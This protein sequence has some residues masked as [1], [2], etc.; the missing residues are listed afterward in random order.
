MDIS[1][2]LTPTDVFVTLTPANTLAKLAFS[3]IYDVLTAG[4]QYG[5]D[6]DAPAVHRMDVGLLQEYDADV[7]LLQR[8]IERRLEEGDG[9]TSQ[10]LTEPNSESEAAEIRLLGMIWTGRFL[11]GFQSPPSAPQIGWTVGKGPLPSPRCA[12]LFLCTIAF[13]RKHGINLRSFHARF[14]FN[15]QNWALFIAR[16]SR[17]PHAE[18]TVNGGAVSSQLYALNQSSMKIRFDKLEYDFKYASFSATD[19]FKTARDSYLTSVLKAPQLVDFEMPTPL[20]SIRT[21]G[22]W[23]LAKPL[24][25][26]GMGR[27]FLASNSKNDIVAVKTVERNPS[28][29]RSVDHEIQTY[30]DLT[31]LAEKWDEGQRIVRVREVIHNRLSSKAPF[32]EVAIVMEPMTPQTFLKLIGRRSMGGAR[33]MS[34]EAARA[35]RDTLLGVRVLH[36]QRWM[37]GDLKPANI[38]MIGTPPR[39]VLLDV[40]QATYLAPSATLD[41]KPG[42]GGTLNYLAPERELE[43][44]DHLV[45]IWSL[46]VIGYELTYGHHPWRFSLNPWR[47]DKKE[48]EELRSAFHEKYQEAIDRLTCDSR[49]TRNSQEHI[50]LGDLL[51]QMLRH[52][53]TRTNHESRIDIDKAL[54]HEAWG[55]LLSDEPRVKRGRPDNYGE[56]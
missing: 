37:H 43:P 32:E 12:D 24:G 29:E 33:G 17:S 23:T 44:H 8:E 28:T 13:A 15:L 48:C 39:A 34:M 20:L 3:D 42:S 19:D 4:R 14:N 35:F 27:V 30:R 7:T 40:G 52:P 11:L 51:V 45:D 38:G 25:R 36:D 22:Q 54:Q 31:A 1:T 47:D 10:S 6:N 9:Y 18:L 49:S 50:H 2:D 56:V 46:G 53:W 55:P 21:I 26:G 41:P 16:G 5:R